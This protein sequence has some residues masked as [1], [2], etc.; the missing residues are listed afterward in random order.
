MTLKEEN[1]NIGLIDKILTDPEVRR[2]LFTN[3]WPLVGRSLCDEVL[4]KSID[5]KEEKK[6]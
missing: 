6:I 3:P 5:K 4:N 2:R 1:K